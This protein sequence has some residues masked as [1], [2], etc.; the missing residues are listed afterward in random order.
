MVCFF[1]RLFPPSVCHDSLLI[2]ATI[3]KSQMLYS[4]F[5]SFSVDLLNALCHQGDVI[6]MRWQANCLCVHARAHCSVYN[7]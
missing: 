7:G 5:R 4:R 6:C 1:F 3:N 2:V